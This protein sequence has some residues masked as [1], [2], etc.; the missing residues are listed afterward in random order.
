MAGSITVVAYRLASGDEVRHVA[1]MALIQ[2]GAIVTGIRNSVKGSTYSQNK[3]GA[4]VKGKPIPT[5][6][7]TSAQTLVRSN[8]AANAKLWSGTLTDAERAAWTFFA[9]NNPYTNVFGETK[10][11]SGMAMMMKLNQVLLG[12]G[13]NAITTPPSD[14]SV[15]DLAIINGTTGDAVAGTPVTNIG[16]A[17]AAQTTVAGAKFYVFATPALAPGKT[18]G[19]SDYRFIGTIAQT[20]AA[21]SIDVSSL[22]AVVFPGAGIAGQ[23][24]STIFST[25]NVA[26]GATT[27]GLRFDQ[28][29]S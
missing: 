18:A 10:Q 1:Y 3:G 17:T 22:Y 15:P 14:L 9:Q 26:S 16:V 25:V 27:P 8:F 5:N 2:L 23:H 20:A 29:I 11:L 12:I 21:T 24:V 4:Y 28:I 19:Q 13:E 7:R 6:P